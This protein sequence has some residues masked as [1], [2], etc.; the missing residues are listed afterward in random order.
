MPSSWPDRAVPS[1][2]VQTGCRTAPCRGGQVADELGRAAVAAALHAGGDEA[3][4]HP[5]AVR[6]G[7]HVQVVHHPDPGGGQRLPGPE[8]GGEADSP[9]GVVAGQQLQPS[10][11]GSASSACDSSSKAW[12]P[13]A[14]W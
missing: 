5:R 1:Y 10:R 3:I 2:T 11:C 12:S 14:T 13:G 8:Q 9:A 6:I 4:S 7:G